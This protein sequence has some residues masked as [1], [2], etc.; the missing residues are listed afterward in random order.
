LEK[1]STNFSGRNILIIDDDRDYADS[2]ADLLGLANYKTHVAYNESQALH[3]IKKNNID[4]AL[5]DI[6]LGQ[7]SGTA[8][9]PKLNA[10][11][12][13]IHCIMV[14]GFAAIETAMQALKNGAYDYLRKPV[15]NNELLAVINRCFEKIQLEDEKQQAKNE[16]K[17]ALAELNILKN[18]LQAENIYLREEIKLNNNF[19]EII[20][21]SQSLRNVLLNVE[22]VAGTE[23]N[24]LILGETGTGKEL[25][26]RSVH[27]LS[28]RREKPL[29]KVNCAVLPSNLIESELF[30]QRTS[31]GTTK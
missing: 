3:I 29:V 12:P 20:G 15:D 19:E 1:T 5:I 26:A 27:Y 16:L 9:I 7:T 23:S 21:K 31:P 4:I 13:G 30:G 2:T 25:I 24:V 17:K 6:R 22:Q 11:S 8:V 14:T 10:I 28:Q 18:R